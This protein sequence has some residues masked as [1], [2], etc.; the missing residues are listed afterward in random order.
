MYNFFLNFGGSANFWHQTKKGFVQMTRYCWISWRLKGHT[1]L[2][3][4]TPITFSF[5][6]KITERYRFPPFASWICK[7][8]K[9]SPPRSPRDVDSMVFI[10]IPVFLDRELRYISWDKC[11]INIGYIWKYFKNSYHSIVLLN[12]LFWKLWDFNYIWNFQ[13]LF[14]KST[15][16]LYQHNKF[17]FFLHNIL[18]KT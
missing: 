10:L 18:G 8:I 11:E 12:F 16:H 5:E 7:T 2:C 14:A 1:C 13:S 17:V 9:L 6:R 4:R 15:N 3:S